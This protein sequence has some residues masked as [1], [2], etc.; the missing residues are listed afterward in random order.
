MKELSIVP[1]INK[2]VPSL[3]LENSNITINGDLEIKTKMIA[4]LDERWIK[5]VSKRTPKSEPKSEPKYIN[6]DGTPFDALT[7]LALHLQTYSR[8]I[9]NVPGDNNC[10]FHA[11]AD[12]L[13]KIIL[14]NG[15]HI[16]CA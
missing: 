14:K 1:Y 2:P 3:K 11:I 6:K 10:Q 8:Q 15:Q 4:D 7:I 16:N 9:V 5:L 12:Q 13:E